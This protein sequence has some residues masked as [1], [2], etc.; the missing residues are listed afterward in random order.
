M[1]EVGGWGDVAEGPP[2]GRAPQGFPGSISTVTAP[3]Q[4]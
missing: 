1:G 3:A 4:C 2:G